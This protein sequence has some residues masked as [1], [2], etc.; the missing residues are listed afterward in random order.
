[1]A[2]AYQTFGSGQVFT[3][4]Q[5]QQIEDNIRDHQHGVDGVG[6]SGA[7]WTTQSVNAAFG[8]A[9]TDAG[10]LYK[11][12]GDFPISA[13]AAATLGAGFGAAFKNV[14]S[15]RIQLNAT[16]GQFI[17]NHSYYAICPGEGIILTSD[18]IELTVVGGQDAAK[19][20][21]VVTTGSIAAIELLKCFPGDFMWYNLVVFPNMN[22]T[23]LLQ[24]QVSSDSG[25]SYL[26]AG[27]GNTTG[28]QTTVG[29]LTLTNTNSRQIRFS[30]VEFGNNPHMNSIAN[31]F[32]AYSIHGTINTDDNRFY[33]T[34]LRGMVNAIKLINDGGGFLDGAIAE[35][36]G[37]GRVRR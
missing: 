23:G 9:S 6:P 12:Y 2:Y 34:S 32:H 15:G 26:A 4:A 28:G 16:S 8:L 25:S 18:G 5:A 30:T 1:M 10:K 37:R 7:A 3:A 11:C 17:D 31:V 33:T 35:L 20:C 24:M 21:R 19:L 27:Y 36:Y 13:A 14:G 29:N 22:G